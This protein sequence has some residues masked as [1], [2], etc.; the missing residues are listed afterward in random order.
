M[1]GFRTHNLT[2]GSEI[3]VAAGPLGYGI[4]GEAGLKSGAGFKAPIFSYVLSKGFFAGVEVVGQ[5]FLDRFDE[6]ERVYWYPGIKAGDIFDGKV[7][8]PAESDRLYA[9]LRDAELGTA[10]GASLEWD[11]EEVTQTLDL[12]EGE[13]LKL[14]PTPEQLQAW[15][16]AGIK[17][18]EDVKHEE[19]ERKAVRSLP[20][21]PRHPYARNSKARSS[22]ASL[23][24]G[25]TAG[26]RS[27]DMGYSSSQDPSQ[28]S[29]PTMPQTAQLESSSSYATAPDLSQVT[30]QKFL[31]PPKRNPARGGV[32][33][34]ASPSGS[35]GR[36]VAPST[37]VSTA[38]TDDAGQ[39]AAI[40]PLHVPAVHA[41]DGQTEE[42]L[43]PEAQKQGLGLVL[44]AEKKEAGAQGEHV[45]VPAPDSSD[46]ANLSLRED[47]GSAPE[48]LE[49][50]QP[51]KLEHQ[52][53]EAS[54]TSV[55]S[56]PQET[57]IPPPPAYQPGEGEQAGAGDSKQAVGP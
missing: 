20:P 17:D 52:D 47:G 50:P 14:P 38:T 3:G 57:S 12:G 4:S 25:R 6:N 24:N 43:I 39:E 34:S 21:P 28:A 10:Q 1:K 41:P 31:P 8:R 49:I 33:G 44:D 53:S 56:E 29:S 27:P 42:T 48:Q 5:A 15:E 7:R 55:Y 19:E 46:M 35:G 16:S 30:S 45:E 22:D 54:F 18:E 23:L 11:T 36:F 37:S 13:V 26:L 9:A 40:E 2:I 51:P 32:T